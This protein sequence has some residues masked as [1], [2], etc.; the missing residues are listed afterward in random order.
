[1]GVAKKAWVRMKQR[2]RDAAMLAMIEDPR[3]PSLLL[4]NLKVRNN[5]SG[6]GANLLIDTKPKLELVSKS[7]KLMSSAEGE[8]SSWDDLGHRNWPSA[9]HLAHHFQ[10]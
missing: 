9:F 4:D 10:T 1:M 7:S 8:R 6:F 5:C 2:A 3:I